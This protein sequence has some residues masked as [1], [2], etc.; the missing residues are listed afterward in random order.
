MLN[1]F[2]QYSEHNYSRLVLLGFNR[3]HPFCKYVDSRNHSMMTKI[4]LTLDL[5]NGAFLLAYLF[6]TAVK[7]T[8]VLRKENQRLT[9]AKDSPWLGH[10]A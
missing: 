1:I 5:L 9:W 6:P 3:I 10:P 8:C 2:L 7:G 4:T